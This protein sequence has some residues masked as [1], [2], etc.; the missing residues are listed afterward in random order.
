V[1]VRQRNSDSHPA[2]GLHLQQGRHEVATQRLRWIR[3]TGGAA[4]PARRILHVLIDGLLE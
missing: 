1:L 2:L 4:D 3:S